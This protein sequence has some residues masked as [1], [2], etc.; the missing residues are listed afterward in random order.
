MVG[1]T[2]KPAC[3]G[4]DLFNLFD[5]NPH[6]T[7]L[8]W[9]LVQTKSLRLIQ[10]LSSGG[11]TPPPDVSAML[12]CDFKSDLFDILYPFKTTDGMHQREGATTKSR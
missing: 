9:E 8:T 12:L 10:K 4:V 7:D 3:V 5:V 11:A 6:T 2:G 1:W